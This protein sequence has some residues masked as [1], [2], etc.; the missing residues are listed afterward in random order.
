MKQK[1]GFVAESEN[2]IIVVF[3][4]AL[5]PELIEEGYFREVV[6]KLQTMRKD[7]GFEVMDKIDVYVQTQDIKEALLKYEDKIK[8]I[9]LADNI[10]FDESVEGGS[11]E[12]EWDINGNK[13]VLAV[14]KA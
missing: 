11:F 3:D 4:T 5:T 7:A 9:V 8:E 13:V 14:K 1:E 10:F 2:G 12:K 6:S